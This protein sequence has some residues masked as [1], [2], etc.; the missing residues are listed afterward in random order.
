MTFNMLKILHHLC[1][2]IHVIYTPCFSC[3]HSLLR[4]CTFKFHVFFY[5]S[6]RFSR[7]L[8]YIF[9]HYH[10]FLYTWSVFI[11]VFMYPLYIFSTCFISICAYP[12]YFLN[13]C[14]H[15]YTFTPPVLSLHVYVFTDFVH[16]VHVLVSIIRFFF[17]ET[18]S[19]N[20]FVLYG[21]DVKVDLFYLHLLLGNA[22]GRSQPHSQW[23]GDSPRA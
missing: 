1:Y 3:V 5:V 9:V 6:V 10:L 15:L 7:I 19:D 18:S 20:W 22:T 2:T 13:T 16:F 11:H 21:L 4:L 23:G 17:G 14:F 8:I 12:L